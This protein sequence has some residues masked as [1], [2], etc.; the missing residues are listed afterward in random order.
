[1]TLATDLS[2]LTKMERAQKVIHAV[3]DH[4]KAHG[5]GIPQGELVHRLGF[6]AKDVERA[7]DLNPPEI[8]SYKGRDGGCFPADVVRESGNKGESLR[9]EAFNILNELEKLD[10]TPLEFKLRIVDLVAKRDAETVRRSEARKAKD[11]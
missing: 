11:D 5:T 1:M 2:K 4:Y 3:R 7:L 10:S 6:S 9:E 8:V